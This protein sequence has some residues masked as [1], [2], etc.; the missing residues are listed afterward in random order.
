MRVS[1][2]IHETG[3]EKLINW[4]YVSGTNMQR[5]HCSGGCPRHGDG[6]GKEPQE[7]II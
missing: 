5:F 3:K 6:S 7:Q 4:K 2:C 1:E